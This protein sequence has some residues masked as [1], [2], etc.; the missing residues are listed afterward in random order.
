MEHETLCLGCALPVT[1]LICDPEDLTALCGRGPRRDHFDDGHGAG[2]DAVGG[3]RTPLVL[4]PAVPA[5]DTRTRWPPGWSTDGRDPDVAF[6]ER[7]TTATTCLYPYRW[8]SNRQ[9]GSSSAALSKSRT[10]LSVGSPNR[11]AA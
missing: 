4:L 5:A 8:A 11:P 6:G 2:L 7:G 1:I 9:P 3:G 10:P